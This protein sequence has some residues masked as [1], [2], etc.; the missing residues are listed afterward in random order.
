LLFIDANK[1]KVL[2]NIMSFT[3]K[4]NYLTL[5]IHLDDYCERGT[6]WKTWENLVFLDASLPTEDY[7]DEMAW[8]DFQGSWGNMQTLV[9][10]FAK[11]S[12]YIYLKIELFT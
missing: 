6:A 12:T 8:A 3:G 2:S 9:I 1:R 11:Y 7:E 5:V 10:I 4:H